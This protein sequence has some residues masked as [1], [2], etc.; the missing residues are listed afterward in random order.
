MKM[1]SF[2]RKLNLLIGSPS[3][4]V[5]TSGY[6]MCLTNLMGYLMSTPVPGFREQKMQP[7]V[8]KG[9]I[10]PRS[11][12]KIVQKAL[13]EGC[14]HLL[15]IDTDQTYPKETAHILLQHQK[16][17][18]GCNIATKEIPANPTA[19]QKSDQ[20][21]G[22][23]VY[24]DPDS[25]PLERVWRLGTGIMLVDMRVFQKIGPGCFEIRWKP[26]IEDYQGED[27]SMCEA[28]EAAGYE[29][30]V[31]HRLSDR[32]GHLGEYEYKHDVIGSR[33]IVE[34]EDRIIGEV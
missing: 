33:E 12:G 25:P 32:I 10:L 26:E 30:W 16:F 6:G 23:P 3:T 19:R 20:F 18:V 5:W 28:I 21:W 9:S 29:I 34:V 1:F 17:V 22:K 8:Q 11:R 14:T 4:G 2:E 15:W 7:L 13:K 24:T 31:D 27:W